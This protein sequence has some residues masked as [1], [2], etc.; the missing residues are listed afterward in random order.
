[1]GNL[2]NWN[3]KRYG[4]V[5]HSDPD[6][7][8]PAALTLLNIKL[9]KEDD[10]IFNPFKWLKFRHKFLSEI[11]KAKGTIE[12]YYCHKKDL[13]IETK[14]KEVL[15]TIDHFK[16][17]SRGGEIWN[18]ANLVPACWRCNCKK[19]DKIVERL[20]NNEICATINL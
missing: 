14:N 6:I 4:R 17:I 10:T 5:L 9:A 8:S 1:M 13:R 15:A 20:T 2:R 19:D 12:C 18:P 11:L 16:P 7:Q 3:L